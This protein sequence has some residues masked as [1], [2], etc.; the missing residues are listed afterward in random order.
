MN[1]LRWGFIDTKELRRILCTLCS[2]EVSEVYYRRMIRAYDN[3][4]DRVIDFNEFI[5]LMTI[6][7]T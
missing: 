2:A 4:R 7:F 5:G 6:N 1:L 3:N